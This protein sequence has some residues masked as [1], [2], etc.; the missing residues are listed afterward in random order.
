MRGIVERGD[1]NYSDRNEVKEVQNSILAIK[2]IEDGLKFNIKSIKKLYHI[3][4]KQSIKSYEFFHNT[5][6][7]Y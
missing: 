2:F 6:K 1:S 7:K 4:V 5:A 3:L